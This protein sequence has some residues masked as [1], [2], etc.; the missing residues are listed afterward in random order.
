M[1]FNK[2]FLLAVLTVAGLL[3]DAQP[4]IIPLPT[5]YKLS[6]DSFALDN[7][8]ALVIADAAF[9][10]EGNYFQMQLLKSTGITLPLLQGKKE[11]TVLLQRA[12][13]KNAM[14]GSYSLKISRNEVLLSAT[15]D[16]GIFYGITS[17]LQLIT[18]KKVVNG[19][20]NIP[21]WEINDKPLYRWRGL[22]LDESRHFF[23]KEKVKS[24][25]DW[26]AF[27]KLNKFHWHLT[28]EPGWRL[29]IKKY[30]LLTLVGGIGS[31]TNPYSPTAFYTQEDVKEIVQYAAERK[32]EVIPEVDMPGH[33][34]AANR[35]YPQFSGGGSEK[36]PD[37]TF[38]PGNEGTYQY[39]TNIIREVDVLFPS[40][41]IHL[42]GDEVS[43]GNQQWGK[44][45][46]I[47]K[48]MASN[49]LKNL[50]DVEDYFMK[51]MADSLY[52]LNSK[53]LAWDEM[54]NLSL[55]ADKTVIF[56]W[57]HDK[58]EQL[59]MAVEKNYSVVL[60]PRIPLYFDF[61]QDSSHTVG[62]KWKTSYAGLG[63]LY[64]FD[65]GSF[66]SKSQQNKVLGIQAN[67]WTEV[68]ATTQRLDYMI[69]PR[70]S[71]LAE[72]AWSEKKNYANYLDRL[73]THLP[74]YEQKG[75]FYY[76]IFKPTRFSEPEL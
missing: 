73:K 62:R 14:K 12:I 27:Y 18:S 15:D 70:I 3:A 13:V 26:M 56:W 21:S 67:V 48:I 64:M 39:L 68:I 45:H 31:H 42:G 17:L 53:F 32:I 9:E 11:R 16:E 37:F 61:V 46:G 7:N 49:N 54:A 63:N 24:L 28:D 8:V 57:R 20:A 19:R 51:R 75:I 55:P 5:E 43:F 33:A 59:K 74:L 22:M 34:R 6:N 36:Y 66:L 50:K 2:Y 47:Q 10:D 40:K 25:L 60:C 72:T 29:E 1:I 41:M 65:A 76:D 38:D 4:S 69:F 23:G 52:K 71:A 58:P 44:N 35:A 30:P